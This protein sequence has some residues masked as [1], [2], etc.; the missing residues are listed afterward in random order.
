MKRQ[1]VGL[2]FCGIAA[3]L[4][5]SRY[6]CVAILGSGSRHSNDVEWFVNAYPFIGSGLSVAALASLVV[7]VAYIAWGEHS[8]LP[9]G[10]A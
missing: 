7:G 9:A 10:K 3:F 4:F 5:A 1:F 2:G 8:D 6:V